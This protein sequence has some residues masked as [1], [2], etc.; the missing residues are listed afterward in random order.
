MKQ[1]PR[2]WIDKFSSVFIKYSFRCTMLDHSV[3]SRSF[4]GVIMLIVYVDDIIIS[5]S[6][7]VGIADLKAYLSLS[8]SL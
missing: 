7:D 6:D 2:A 5:E 8:V 3:F 4:I 1:S